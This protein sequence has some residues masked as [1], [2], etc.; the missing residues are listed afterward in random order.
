MKNKKIMKYTINSSIIIIGAVIITILLNAI[1]VAFDSKIP[2]EISLNKDEIFELTDESKEIVAQIDED[3]QIIVLFD[4]T[5]VANDQL[6]LLT[7]I[8]EKYAYA[9]EKITFKTV[10]YYNDPMELV[11]NYPEAIKQI[12]DPRYAMIFVQGD[13]FEVAESQ[14]YISDSGKSNI[15]RIV[16]N[17]LAMFSD[18]FRFS[19]IT[20]TTGHGEKRNEV[21]D[22]V[23]DMYDYRINTVDLLKEDFPENKESLVI[24]DAPT[25][26]FTAEEIEKL[27]A[28]LGRGGNVQI[29]FN[30]LLSNDELPRLE[31]YLADEW[32]IKRGHKVIVDMDNKLES[33]ETEEAVYGI[34]SVAKLADSEIV[35]PMKSSQRSVLYSAS[36]PLDI[37][38]DKTASLEV[39]PVLSTASGAYLKD[40]TAIKDSKTG[41]E[42]SGTFH[43]AL[44]ATKSNY[45]LDDEVFT[46]KLLV[47]GSGYAM[48]TLVGSKA[49]ANEDLLMNSFSWMRGSETGITV[50]EKDLPTGS[51]T[52]PGSHFWPWFIVLVVVIPIALLAGG[53]VIWM[54]R[55]YK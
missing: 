5:T 30:P 54:K 9:N 49:C 13:K 27:D 50:R 21:F 35:A 10:D 31:K 44:T 41:E 37:V 32:G 3:T 2:L 6:T 36:N 1:L 22:S 14:S 33:G 16:T 15:E 17:K 11:M 28:Y 24:I 4:G 48:D 7:G 52:V 19:E 47:C 26:D 18:G 43:I 20:L 38:S 53:V 40:V 29:Y 55:R 39:T 42:Q 34:L 25:M 23:M 46:G 12:S 45:T 8:L 51:L